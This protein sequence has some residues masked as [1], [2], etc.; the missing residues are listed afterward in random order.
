MKR[1]NVRVYGIWIDDEKK[2]LLSDERIR[3]FSFTKFPG[4]GL[5]FGE[6]LRDALTREWREELNVSIEVLDHIYTTD[7]FQVSAFDQESQVIS[8]YYKV[9]PVDYHPES[10]YLSPHKFDFTMQGEEEISFRK[11]FL[12]ELQPDHLT[13]PIDR[14]IVPILQQH[15]SRHPN[16]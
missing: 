8:V 7:F 3:D 16:E 4:G 9:K 5:E 11:V 13:L 15:E 10:I 14:F 2:I 12:H 1:F 6:G